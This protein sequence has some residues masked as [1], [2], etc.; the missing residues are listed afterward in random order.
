MQGG[1][2]CDIRQDLSRYPERDTDHETILH[3]ITN[4]LEVEKEV[5]TDTKDKEGD[6]TNSNITVESEYEHTGP[7]EYPTRVRT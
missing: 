7:G 1:A 6:T 5:N 3:I 2:I 4:A